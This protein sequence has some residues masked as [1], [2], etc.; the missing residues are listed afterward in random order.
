VIDRSP[1][2]LIADIR[3]LARPL[4]TDADLDP[5]IARAR[6]RRFVAIGEASH[7]THDYY[8]W[9]N[10]LTRRLI[11]EQDVGWIGVEGDWPDCWRIDRWVRGLADQHLDARTLLA[12]F[13]RWPTWMW[14]NAEVAEFIDW[15]RTWNADRPDA[16]QVGFY[17]LDVYSLW[18]SL[19]RVIGW[20]GAHAPDALPDAMRAWECFQPYQEDPHRY[21]WST[22][23]VPSSCEMDVVDLLVGVRTLTASD[24]DDAFD[25]AQNAAIAVGAERYYR[26]MV[27]TDRESWNIRDIHMA[28][29]IDR[30]ARRHRPASKGV[31]WEHNTHVGDARGTPMA[32]EGMVNVGQLLRERHGDEGVLLIGFAGH[33]GDV[34][35]GTHWGSPEQRMPV[36]EARPGSHEH[37]V[38][39]ALHAP[40][41]LDF[42]GDRARPWLSTAAGHRAIGVVYSPQREAGN[43]VPTTMGRRYDALLWLEETSALTP[44]HH[45]GPPDEPEFE[46]EPTGF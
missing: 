33:R 23:L 34:I 40:A 7:G 45:E 6:D 17:G 38:H 30:L 28:D 18:D 29:T 1:A 37:L 46:T 31:I 25:A 39:E 14:A 22:R 15:L 5:L 16:A 20:V 19:D 21:A 36:P 32:G 42:G 44:L 27:R 41:V 10:R 4:T 2:A 43:Y 8:D 12:G 24:G 26:A 35:A 9:R 13:D 11:Q 3:A